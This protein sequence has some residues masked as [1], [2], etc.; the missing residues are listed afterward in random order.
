MSINDA[1]KIIDDTTENLYGV[2]PY[3][4]TPSATLE[5][6]KHSPRTK[7]GILESSLDESEQDENDDWGAY[8]H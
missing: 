1:M 4:T 8:D 6:W 2:R 3:K 5:Y 7:P